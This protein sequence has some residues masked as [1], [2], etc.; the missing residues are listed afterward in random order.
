MTEDATMDD[1]S[2]E[3]GSGG[4]NAPGIRTTRLVERA[5]AEQWPIPDKLRPRLVKKL[6]RIMMDPH[7][8]PREATSAAK[9]LLAASKI[10]LES[11]GT[12]MKAEEHED[13]IDRIEEL[14]RKAPSVAPRSC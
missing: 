4:T 5:I 14:E 2:T 1:N 7:V 6:S 3:G 10:N 13:L 11:I 12:A 8:S 9:A